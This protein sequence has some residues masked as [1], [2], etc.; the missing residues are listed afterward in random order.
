V[1]AIGNSTLVT[2]LAYEPVVESGMSKS[3][4]LAMALNWYQDEANW[5][6]PIAMSGPSSW[7]RERPGTLV[8]PGNGVPVAKTTVSGIRTN[9]DSISFS[10]SK[11]GVPVLVKIPYFPNWQ[12][13][14]ATGPYPVTPN[15]M[16]VVPTHHTVTLTYGTTTVDWVGRIGSALGIAGLLVL[17]T[18]TDP[19]PPRSESIGSGWGG[20]SDP[21][22][23]LWWRDPP[24]ADRDD[25]QDED[26][27]GHSPDSGDDAVDP[28]TGRPI[29]PRPASSD[30]PLP[31]DAGP[32]RSP[33]RRTT[34]SPDGD[35][36]GRAISGPMSIDGVAEDAPPI[37]PP[38]DVA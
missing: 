30:A 8:G 27:R 31:G 4:W 34:D 14:G 16:V 21:E 18:P 20:S 24:S 25:D 37:P 1:Y 19:G 5:P 33:D 6:V 22:H 17:R 23:P 38:P 29:H 2:P 12:A 13:N 36:Q 3:A 15:L 32:D 10:V 9:L 35:D 28:F 7:P 26:G 11:V